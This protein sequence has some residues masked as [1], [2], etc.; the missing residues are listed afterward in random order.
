MKKYFAILAFTVWTHC[1]FGVSVIADPYIINIERALD[2]YK[3]DKRFDPTKYPT[4][5]KEVVDLCI[6]VYE[7]EKAHPEYIQCLT[8]QDSYFY[9]FQVI[10]KELMLQAYGI[11]KPEF[12]FLRVPT[13]PL[14]KSKKEFFTL[15]PTLIFTSEDFARLL[16]SPIEKIEEKYE[17]H[18]L[19]MENEYLRI[20]RGEKETSV[21][22]HE[23]TYD[24]TRYV[25]N[26]TVAEVSKELI[27]VSFTMETYVPLDSALSVFLSGQSVSFGAYSES[28][29]AY[30]MQIKKIVGSIFNSLDIPP[31][32]IQQCIDILVA[33]APHTE[34]G[35]I[36]QVLIPQE[37]AQEIMYIALG[38]GF[39]HT[40]YDDKF[41]A[42]MDKFTQDR[43]ST[44]FRTYRNFQA[45][46]IAGAIYG[47]P[48]VK[49][50]R[51]T[52]I[53]EDEQ[54][55]YETLVRETI[56]ELLSPSHK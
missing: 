51:Y 11:E 31:K 38:G 30:L 56:K 21:D 18:Q 12:E 8:A 41:T 55:A 5:H 39:L 45:R 35:I 4:L 20:S 53:P 9:A 32:D 36:N 43:Q 34:C 7:S 10:A 27:S 47:H 28:E 52:L 3:F 15:F 17:A 23:D 40:F 24:Y 42:V 29:D 25:I 33:N 50:Y 48:G 2:A 54:K 46:I 49:I 22:D 14:A 37:N 13:Q 19:F 6:E 26:D 1:C 16:Q 44:N